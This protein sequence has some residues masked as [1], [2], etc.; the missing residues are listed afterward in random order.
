M[1]NNITTNDLVNKDHSNQS[2]LLNEYVQKKIRIPL[3]NLFKRGQSKTDEQ[4]KL[5]LNM[6]KNNLKTN[7]SDTD[8]IWSIVV[9][10]LLDQ[11]MMLSESTK[12]KTIGFI[13]DAGAGKSSL[14]NSILNCELL[15]TD[16]EE[17]C[18]AS[19]SAISSWNES[20]YQLFVYFI[21]KEQWQLE[22]TDACETRETF[23]NDTENGLPDEVKAFQ[24][25]QKYLFGSNSVQEV[26]LN[27]L[28]EN[29]EKKMIK[30]YEQ[31]TTHDLKILKQKLHTLASRNGQLWP[32]VSKI[33][34]R[35]PFTDL[36]SDIMLLDIPG[37]GDGYEVMT[38]RAAEAAATC[39]QLVQVVRGDGRAPF[40]L[41]FLKGLLQ[42]ST[43]LKR[44]SLV[45]THRN[46]VAKQKEKKKENNPT[47][48][49]QCKEKLKNVAGDISA[50]SFVLENVYKFID[51][52]AIYYLENRCEDSE[53]SEDDKYRLNTF[54]DTEFNN[55]VDE[56]LRETRL[57]I[58]SSINILLK[59]LS[60][61]L[62]Q[63]LHAIIHDEELK[64]FTD[65]CLSEFSKAI[66]P[67]K[68]YLENEGEKLWNEYFWP[69]L[70]K[71]KRNISTNGYYTMNY[72]TL[73]KNLTGRDYMQISHELSSGMIH[74]NKIK[75]LPT[76]DSMLRNVTHTDDLQVIFSEKLFSL[77][78][79]KF[80]QNN[81]EFSHVI[82]NRYIDKVKYFIDKF[83]ISINNTF[84][85]MKS[86]MKHI[87]NIQMSDTIRDELWIRDDLR[88]VSGSGTQKRYLASLQKF[89]NKLNVS[90]IEF[91]KQLHRRLS[92]SF[93]EISDAFISFENNINETINNMNF[94]SVLDN[95]LKEK[96]LKILVPLSS[97]YT[98]VDDE[99]GVH[100]RTEHTAT[101]ENNT[102]LDKNENINN[103][104]TL[105]NI[106]QLN[107]EILAAIPKTFIN[108]SINY[109]YYGYVYVL[110]NKAMPNL[111]KIGYTTVN[112]NTRAKNLYTTGVPLHFIVEKS[113]VCHNCRLFEQWMHKLFRNHR[114]N[115]RREFFR[116]PLQI[117]IDVG[118]HLEIIMKEI[119][120][121]N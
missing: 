73:R 10:P 29:I 46:A 20:Y 50:D 93:N 13:G 87:M 79:A 112:P 33:Y 4:S 113:Y 19:I 98:Q 52:L 94:V 48:E 114:L 58:V 35:G 64:L 57:D 11:I 91:A 55:V 66:G 95:Q 39:D 92:V 103:Q 100:L 18:T 120:K 115:N 74:E 27:S 32:I 7:H 102:L 76:A 1:A 17:T 59:I 109:V 104:W 78:K 6:K 54:V 22:S 53:W 72:Q 68:L 106:H 65:V 96:L 110:S 49:E 23:K 45:V 40:T 3:E 30:G 81:V 83:N 9:Q 86:Q 41:N 88:H 34:I 70:R 105:S 24:L 77:L 12:Q 111:Y 89:I 85:R 63:P 38:I 44:L 56:E 60:G 28:P 80:S 26:S 43:S 61:E 47:L 31:Y 99:I 90:D 21:S 8:K 36:S 101:T 42:S 119:F 121:N 97:P 67:L 82:L 2:L 117:I 118:N 116:V 62:S 107:T 51:G 71:E 14:I 16:Y 25:K 69:V 108:I 37:Y 75:E 84:K 15:P 5:E